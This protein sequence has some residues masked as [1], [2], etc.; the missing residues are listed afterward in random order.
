M[1]RQALFALLVLCW[2]DIASANVWSEPH[3]FRREALID[4]RSFEYDSRSFLNRLSYQQVF[5]R[6][7]DQDGMFGTAGSVSST[8][9]YVDIAMQKTLHF[10]DDRHEIRVNYRRAEDFDGYFDRQKVG[11]GLNLSDW[12]LGVAGDV[13]GDKAETDVYW[14]LDWA[15][16][17]NTFWRINLILPDAYLNQ[18]G[19]AG[20]VYSGSAYSGFVEG[21]Q[22]FSGWSW[23]AVLN[24]TP[25]ITVLDSTANIDARGEQHRAMLALTF[26]DRWQT[27][28]RA[29]REQ[30]ER[31]FVVDPEGIADNKTFSRHMQAYH[32]SLQM[33]HWYLT[34]V[35]GLYYLD[36]EEDGWLGLDQALTVRLR[37]DERY[38]FVT[39]HHALTERW[40]WQPTVYLGRSEVQRAIA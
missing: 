30:T 35:V 11:Y 27:K 39:L 17:K 36:L 33:N 22:E 40:Q 13:R 7:V 16:S 2:N 26:G 3:P 31:D 6:P 24:T 25:E 10:D 9:L 32:A 23:Q 12:R 14:E 1:V 19:E 28:L 37:H 34:P 29:E 20:A 5:A 15:P 18:K 38:G 4:G 21:R 8:E